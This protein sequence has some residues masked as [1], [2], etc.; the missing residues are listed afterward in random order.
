LE[1]I[2]I[3]SGPYMANTYILASENSEKACII[4]PSCPSVEIMAAASKYHVTDIIITHGHF[5]HIGGNRRLKELLSCLVHIRKEDSDMLTDPDKNL[6]SY[7]GEKIVSPPADIIIDKDGQIIE[8]GLKEL[9]FIHTPG[10][11]EGS[12]SI[13]APGEKILFS[14]D[15]IFN[16]SMGRTDFPGGDELKMVESIK[17]ILNYPDDIR[18]YPGHGDPFILSDFKNYIK[19]YNI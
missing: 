4:D 16:R 17:M 12:V 13:Y 2:K 1:V 7:T 15:F 10:H 5:D 11:S 9:V 18:V 14:G 19:S 6:S 8:F 3:D